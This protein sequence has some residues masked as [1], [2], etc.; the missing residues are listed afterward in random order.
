MLFAVTHLLLDFIETSP[1][2]ISM[3]KLENPYKSLSVLK[4]MIHVCILFL[5]G[6]LCFTL[7]IF[8]F[9]YQY[10]IAMMILIL[11]A[12]LLDRDL[13]SIGRILK[14]D[15]IALR[16]IPLIASAVAVFFILYL[17]IRT[18]EEITLIGDTFMRGG[19][20]ST[21]EYG[22]F[23]IFVLPIVE[24][25]FFR[26]YLQYNLMHRIGT[27]AAYIV[28]SFIYAIFFIFT[29]NI[30]ILAIFLILG[31]YMGYIFLKNKST[32]INIAIHSLF[33]LLLFIYPS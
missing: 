26:G 10:A 21:T 4:L 33:M 32:L 8:S 7:H 29:K 22:I 11:I 18:P 31:F 20:I 30:W 12:S 13:V 27:R 25:V 5:L 6:Y 15:F 3:V 28:A 9:L 16:W 24:E 14:V 17:I 23:M 19:D 2:A 1:I